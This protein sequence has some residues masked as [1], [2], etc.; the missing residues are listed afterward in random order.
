MLETSILQ[1]HA[2]QFLYSGKL[3]AVAG[4]VIVMVNILQALRF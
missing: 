4:H 1:G 3:L 2:A